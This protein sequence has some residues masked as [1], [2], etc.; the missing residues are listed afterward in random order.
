MKQCPATFSDGTFYYLS[1]LLFYNSLAASL[2]STEKSSQ[3]NRALAF[4]DKKL[5]TRS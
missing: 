5:Q 4:K 1:V 2:H 3:N